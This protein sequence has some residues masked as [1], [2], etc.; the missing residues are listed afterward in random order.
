MCGWI[1]VS[2]L[3]EVKAASKH[4]LGELYRSRCG[5]ELDLRSIK[6]LLGM[7]ELRCKT[8]HM[9]HPEI[10]AYLLGYNLVCAVMAQAANAVGVL[11][12][13][14]SFKATLSTLRAFQQELRH[15][16]GRRGRELWGYV[17]AAI[18]GARLLVRPTRVEPRAV[19][20]RPEP[21]PRLM[22]ERSLARDR[23]L[24]SHARA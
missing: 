9:V 7:G 2:T 10:S 11:P 18:A 14:L 3:L 22:L 21:Y 23:L 6:E 24:Q 1:L 15:H 4:E 19:K 12:R 20:R 17:L 13:R 5:I 8:P 16:A